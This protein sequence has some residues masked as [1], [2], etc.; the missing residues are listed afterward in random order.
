MAGSSHT[1]SSR[2]SQT[3]NASK[4][5]AR[6]SLE[7]LPAELLSLIVAR[8]K[9]PDLISLAASSKALISIA[10]AP[11]YSNIGVD[12]KIPTGTAPYKLIEKAVE[13]GDT[14]RMGTGWRRCEI[15]D[16]KVIWDHLALHAIRC[17]GRFATRRPNHES[18]WRWRQEGTP[19]E[20]AD[21]PRLT[22]HELIR[23]PPITADARRHGRPYHIEDLDHQSRGW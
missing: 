20:A 3:T 23:E 21:T 19:G 13:N 16:I 11:I 2:R 8:P 10:E 1:A 7:G 22:H 14:T 6:A 18:K 15:C 9:K 17:R 12:P 5:I 4:S